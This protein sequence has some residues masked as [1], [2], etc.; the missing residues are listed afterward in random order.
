MTLRRRGILFVL[1]APSGAG[2]STLLN[3]IRPG[4]DFTFSISCTT[5]PPRP[6]ELD[7]RDY[8]FLSSDDFER[9]AAAGEFLEY[10]NVHG[11]YYGTLR[12]AVLERLEAG[13]DVLLEIDVQGAASIRSAGGAIADSLVDV[14]MMP[15]SLGELD[16][17]LH[18]RGT[19]DPAQIELRLANA[20]RE[21]ASWPEFRY[22]LITTTVE[23]DV[24]NFTAI[25]RAERQ[26]ARRIVH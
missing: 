20:R 9:K 15:E 12:S 16:R 19:E 2:K 5:R 26:A 10:A 3:A 4:A 6:G 17:R 25:V 7:G 11:N 1:S 21:I 23:E 18:K 24:A 13:E 14:F 8:H 22:L